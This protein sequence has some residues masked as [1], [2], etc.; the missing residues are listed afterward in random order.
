MKKETVKTP[1][2]KIYEEKQTVSQKHLSE[3]HENKICIS[4]ERVNVCQSNSSPQEITQKK[5]THFVKP[6][7]K[8]PS[9]DKYFDMIKTSS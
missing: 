8:K 2:T 1:V 5:V 9:L 3:E 6:L 7:F 4:K